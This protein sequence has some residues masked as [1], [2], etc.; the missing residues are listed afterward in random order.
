MTRTE[1][2][3]WFFP[4]SRRIFAVSLAVAWLAFELFMDPRGFW[5]WLAA[6]IVAYGIWDFFLSGNY[7]KRP[8]GG[9]PGDGEQAG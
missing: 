4:L 3:P 9:G 6:G 8:D 7:A 2:H 5:C 1:P